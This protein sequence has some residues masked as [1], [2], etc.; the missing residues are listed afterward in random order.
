MARRREPPAL[1]RGQVATHAVHLADA[2]A[3]LQQRAVD[4]LL[5]FE[6]QAPQWRNHQRRTA[7]GNEAKHDI[8]FMEPGKRFEQP[9]RWPFAGCVGNRVRG[10]DDLDALARYRISVAGHH[11]ARQLARPV[12]LHRLR[13]RRGR[14]AGANHDQAAR[15]RRRQKLRRTRSAGCAAAIAALNIVSRSVLGSMV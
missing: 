4:R 5:V 13:H 2:G 8:I 12:I 9:L 7:A 10:L 15:W 3:R 6:R 11:H 1:D 14:L